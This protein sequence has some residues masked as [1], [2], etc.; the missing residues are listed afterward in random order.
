[1]SSYI[2]KNF[3]EESESENESE[4]IIT[5]SPRHNKKYDNESESES[6]NESESESENESESESENESNKKSDNNDIK[7]DKNNYIEY[8][9]DNFFQKLGQYTFG[10]D[11]VIPWEDSNFV[12]SGGLLYDIITGR[13]EQNL[14][15]I[16][17]FFYG[18]LKSKHNTINKLLDNLDKEQYYYLIGYNGSVI[19]IFIQGIPRI[20]QL[21]MT[22]KKNPEE[23]IDS[24]DVTHVMSYS[25]GKKIFSNPITIEQFVT[26][27]T[28][29]KIMH[30]NRLIKYLERGLDCKDLLLKDY[31]FVINSEEKEKILKSHVQRKLYNSTYNL[32][33]Y[34]N[35]LTS[36]IDFTKFLQNKIDLKSYFGCTVNYNKLNNHDFKENVNMFGAFAD[37][38]HTKTSIILNKCEKINESLSDVVD[39]H[40]FELQQILSDQSNGVLF[41]LFKNSLIY[42]KCKFIKAE[43]FTKDLKKNNYEYIYEES[44]EESDEEIN[45]KINE[46]IIKKNQYLIKLFIEIND[47]EVINYLR[48]KI[49]NKQ[50][51]KHLDFKYV[52]DK[53]MDNKKLIDLIK[54]L[55]ED[56][57][58][59]PFVV[60]DG[61]EQNPNKLIICASLWENSIIKF[62]HNSGKIIDRLVP[63]QDIN[64][65]L[66]LSVYV[67]TNNYKN[68]EFIDVNLCPE[69]IFA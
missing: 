60:S 51:L 65:I 47:E 63:G 14:M 35:E 11:K 29:I 62:E 56:K 57:I 40:N 44:D 21:I 18:D 3:S 69:Y 61:Q 4:D 59:F 46:K 58:S 24:F 23:I 26:K 48:H 10:L 5:I 27:K 39:I 42:T 12:F 13:F 28:T 53:K 50:L 22:N 45:E 67:K 55:D 25:D 1:M 37:Y 66:N 30:K 38:M 54:I 52:C 33:R 41:S 7:V 17:L 9:C 64:C 43:M 34:P 32:T 20:I 49:N 68:V 16:D 6:E 31:N 36:Q 8:Q 2:I 19:Y 15:D